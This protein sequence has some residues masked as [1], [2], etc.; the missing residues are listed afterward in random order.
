MSYP[1]VRLRPKA[2][3]RAIR[4]GFPWVYADELVTDRRTQALSPG[5]LAVLEDAERRA[6][7]LV[8]VNPA[9]KIIARMLDRDPDATIDEGWFAARLSRALALRARL[10]DGPFYRLIHAEADGLP[11]V[12]IDRFGDA[13][14]IQPNAA[15]AEAHL[16]ALEAALVSVTG[17]TTVIKNGAGRARSLEGLTEEIVVL[18][19]GLQGPVPVPMNGA[20]YMADLTGGQKTGLFYDQRPN[21]AFGARLARGA[22]VLDVFTHVGGFALAALAGGA[23]RAL[24][25]DA[26]GPALALAEAGAAAGGMADRFATRQGDA[27]EVLEALGAEGAR[28][29]LVICDPP[30]FAPSKPALEAGLRAYERLARLAAPL[31]APGGF[32]GLCSCSHAADLSAFRNACARGIG[33]GGRRG[34]LIHTGF[35]GPDHPVLPQLAESGY[36]KALF[37]RLDG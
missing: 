18:R 36:L 30:A 33:R 4:H 2:E 11:G 13:A 26:S 32:L 3:A 24:G 29:D 7:G 5:A 25:V 16:P 37:F 28:F 35:A 31:V 12:V 22:S 17:V 6:M 1:T 19:G 15:W 14:V 23:G 9:S 27:F 8:T 21:H 20:T 10:F 34:Q